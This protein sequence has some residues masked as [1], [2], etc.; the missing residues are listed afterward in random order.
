MSFEDRRAEIL[1]LVV[2][3]HGPVPKGARRIRTVAGT[4]FLVDEQDF[5]L[6]SGRTWYDFKSRS[7]KVYAKTKIDGRWVALH[8]LIVNPAAGE[9]VAYEDGNSLNCR[10][11][12]LRCVT[13]AQSQ[14]GRKTQRNN[15]SGYRGVTYYKR[16]G[17]WA[18]RITVNGKTTHLGY[19]STPETAAEVYREA[20]LELHGQHTRW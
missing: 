17:K 18:A 14:Q 6:V 7:G 20:A 15:T 12:N 3:R 19:Y 11:A 5:E 4:P 1:R 13:H 2:A 8:R 16:F 9:E 10:R